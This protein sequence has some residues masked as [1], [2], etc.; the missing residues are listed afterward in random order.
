M[1]ARGALLA[2]ALLC[3]GGYA[4]R[5]RLEHDGVAWGMG[6]GFRRAL[7]ATLRERGVHARARPVLRRASR[8][9]HRAREGDL[10]VAVHASVALG[11][12]SAGGGELLALG[13]AR[14]LG[15][16]LLRPD[17]ERRL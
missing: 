1:V 14:H 5:G 12:L 7:V 13:R 3:S 10:L 8:Y 11:E 16:G 15:G 9:V 2:G 17:R 4:L 6:W